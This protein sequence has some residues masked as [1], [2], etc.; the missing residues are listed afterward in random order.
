MM[1]RRLRS[2]LA[3]RRGNVAVV[4]ALA[5]A[6]LSLAALGALDIARATAAKLELQDALDAATLATAKSTVSD[7]AVLQATGDRIFRQNL[8]L[9]SDVTLS[10]DTFTFGTG[11]TVV[12]SA[13][14]AVRPLIIGA[15]TGG[16]I[17]VGAHTEV[18]RAGN[19]LEI[20]LVLDNTGSMAGTKLS[21]LKTAASNFIDSMSAA[22]AQ[23]GDANAIK[24]SLVPFSNTVRV[25]ATYASAAWIDQAGASPINNEIFTTSSGT[26]WANRFTLFSNLGATWAGC[27][28]N[29]QA[30]YDIQDTPPGT[31]ATV[32]TPYFAPDEPDWNGYSNDYVSDGS[33]SN[34]WLVR[35]GKIAKYATTPDFSHGK[36][37]NWGCTMQ[38]LQRLSTN[39]S[40]LK[41]AVNA[42]QAGGDTNIPMGMMWGWHTLS[43]N[44]PFA[45]G[46]AYLTAKHKKIVILM[47]DGQNTITDSGNANDSSYSGS[48]YIWQGRVL[49]ASG[50][51]LAG[52]NSSAERTAALDDRLSK[53]CTNMKAVD[54]DIEVYTMRVEVVGGTSTVLQNCAS[55]AD[56]YFDV[57]NAADLNSVFQTIAGQIAS[58][59]LSK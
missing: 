22:A 20:A 8:T 47:T 32:F 9:D 2:A 53:L 4:V 57:Q 36:G 15:I 24:I 56:H 37:P 28:E 39:W 3:D 41:T 51:P 23:T 26:Q 52:S 58:L 38:T 35:Q 50:T 49:Q 19:E 7:S 54:K 43:P 48:G 16:P 44:A 17:N 59:H 42:M 25:G 33:N 55:G 34:S 12:A 46:V 13:S 14:A 18:K 40:A 10:A 21:N 6:P 45:D 30:P 5:L 29:R 27:V 1:F 31:G 11:G